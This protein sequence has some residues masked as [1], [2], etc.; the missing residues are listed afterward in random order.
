MKSL[1][2]IAAAG[3]AVAFV[4]G[5]GCGVPRHHD[6][7]YVGDELEQ[8]TGHGLPVAPAEAGIPPGVSLD[9]GLSEDEAVA[10]ALWN[11]A[12]FQTL[13]ADLALTRADLIKANLLTNPVFAVLFPLGPKQL[14]FTL[15]LPIEALWL[16]PKRVAA[17]TIDANRIADGLVQN[18]LDLVRD[19]RVA[20]E[21]LRLA[22]RRVDLADASLRLARDIERDSK[23]RLRA[24]EAS[25]LEAAG[26]R[27]ELVLAID[28]AARTQR[29]LDVARAR[30]A[31]LLGG[32]VAVTEVTLHDASP[33]GMNED[34]LVAKAFA[35]RPDMRAAELTVDGA[36]ERAGLSRYEVLAISGIADANGSGKEG[37]EIGPGLE[38]G[39]PIFNWNQGGMARADA[40]LERALRQLRAVRQRVGLEVR[41]AAARLKNATEQEAMWRQH[42]LPDLEDSTRRAERAHKAGDIPLLVVL[43]TNA[44]LI[45]SRMREAEATAEIGR[46]RAELERTV[47]VRLEAP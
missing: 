3:G 11:N 20:C 1:L 45:K 24:G 26:P 37:F 46:A 17:A 6:E 39:I 2:R 32:S 23:E 42:I 22:G 10:I 47:G 21:N 14:E 31:A 19:V 28:E 7:R 9:D 34:E 25:A 12:V 13:L 5:L 29:D 36:R 8:R 30:V 40:E 44:Q 35:G 4:V 38:T 33:L 15:K 27:V 43:Q 18:G 41:E 16:R